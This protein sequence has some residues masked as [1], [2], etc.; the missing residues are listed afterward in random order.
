MTKAPS[1]HL[2]KSI[3]VKMITSFLVPVVF[4][5]ILGSISYQKA[6]TGLTKRY[7]SS[8]ESA[9]ILTQKYF[10]VIL[11]E[12]S[13]KPLQLTQS[14]NIVKYYSGRFSKNPVEEYK[15]IDETRRTLSSFVNTDEFLQDITI[16]SSY[17]QSLN[18]TKLIPQNHYKSFSSSSDLKEL[19]TSESSGMWSG[20]HEYLDNLLHT[21]PSKYFLTYISNFKS[22]TSKDIGYIIMDLKIDKLKEALNDMNL[23]TGSITALISGDNKEIIVGAK[24]DD[25]SFINQEF[26]KKSKNGIKNKKSDEFRIDTVFVKGK[27]FR[28]FFSYNS[29]NNLTLCT[30]I[31]KNVIIKQAVELRNITFILVAI[32]CIIAGV[33][34]MKLSTGIATTITTANHYLTKISEGNLSANTLTIKRKDEFSLLIR[35]IFHMIDRMKD[36]I[37]KMKAVSF[38]VTSTSGRIIENTSLLLTSTKD[39]TNSI[40]DIQQGADQQANDAQSCLLKMETLSNQINTMQNNSDHMMVTATTTKDTVKESIVV[41]DTLSKKAQDTS[42]IT[43]TIIQDIIDLEHRSN[44][45]TDF[46]HIINELSEQTNLLS[47]NASIEAARA[48]E[49]GK[50]FAVIADSIRKLAEQSKVASSKINEIIT[51]IK[52][53]THKTVETAHDAKSIVSSQKLALDS[54]IASFKSIDTQ[55]SALSEH[56]ST[57][58]VGISEIE[59]AK[60]ETL[61]AVESISAISEENA[62]ATEVL[63]ETVTT[64][65]HVVTILDEAIHHLE[66]NAEELNQSV[67]AFTI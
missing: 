37:G 6:S 32:A 33:I 53:Q 27:E 45:I 59:Q 38:E 20:K 54:T 9:L 12:I 29:K 14:P 7:E 28:Y 64:Q 52:S 16:I 61:Q 15:S 22:T 18:S 23:D 26:Y 43:Q 39:I 41:I 55:V 40:E 65:L 51:D 49:S 19:I 11:N 62:A 21:D 36:L 48:G 35:G 50:G 30:I 63:S 56:I 60:T 13:T 57:I 8:T 46:V 31:P 3:R 17:G 58:I 2:F 47:L 1:V 5:I 44:Q 4:I 10:Q 25:F 42:H 66:V 34:G 67:K 24:T